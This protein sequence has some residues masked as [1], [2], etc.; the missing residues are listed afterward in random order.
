MD[1]E[2]LSWI[3]LINCGKRV[4]INNIHGARGSAMLG[5]SR[6]FCFSRGVLSREES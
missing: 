1:E 3:K 2:D 4:E 5:T 6:V